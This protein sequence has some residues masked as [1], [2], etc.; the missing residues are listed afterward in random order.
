VIGNLYLWGNVTEYVI[1]HFHYL[2]DEDST[3]SRGAIVI[4]LS[5]TIQCIFNPLSAYLQKRY[6]PKLIMLGGSLIVLGSVYC[7][8]HS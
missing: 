7:A 8:A 4:P 5:F 2:G 3:P 6:N 1:S